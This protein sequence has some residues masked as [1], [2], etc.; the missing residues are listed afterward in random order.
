MSILL[1]SFIREQ[2]KLLA[3]SNGWYYLRN[4][5]IKENYFCSACDAVKGIQ[6]HH[7]KPVHLFPDLELDWDNLISLCGDC[8]FVIGHSRNWRKYNINVIEVCALLKEGIKG[9]ISN[10]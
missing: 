3:R 5:F 10:V 8:H 1:N 7:I 2:Y 4:E 9:K 6:V